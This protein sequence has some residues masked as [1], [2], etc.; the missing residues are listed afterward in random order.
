VAKQK[1]AAEWKLRESLVLDGLQM[2]F[3][4]CRVPLPSPVQ[5]Q[6]RSGPQQVGQ[7]RMFHLKLL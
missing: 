7:L 3:S 1:L 2:P 6:H 5:L 4:D